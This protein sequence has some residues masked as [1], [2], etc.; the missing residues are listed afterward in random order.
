MTRSAFARIGRLEQELGELVTHL[1]GGETHPDYSRFV[2]D[3]K[4]WVEHVWPGRYWWPRM[5]EAIESVMYHRLVRVQSANGLGKTEGFAL[6]VLYCVFVLGQLVIITSAV[7]RQVKHGF[8][9]EIARHVMTAR[10]KLWGDLFRM[11]LELG[12]GSKA[13]ILAFSAADESRFQGLHS[14]NVTVILD[15]AQGL[16]EE[17][18]TAAMACAVSEDSRVIALGNPLNPTG[19]FYETSRSPH[20]KSH[21]LSALDFINVTE[22]R[23][24]VPGAATRGFINSIRDTYGESSPQYIARVTGRYPEESEEALIRLSWIEHAVEQWKAGGLEHLAEREPFVLACDIA[25]YGRDE[26]ILAVRHGPIL[27]ELVAWRG[28]STQESAERI[29]REVARLEADGCTVGLVLVDEVGV[30]GGVL[31]SL[32]ERAQLNVLGFNSS[33]AATDRARFLN[34]RAEAHWTLRR[35]LE[36]G[37]IALPEDD[38]LQEELGK[39]RW[40]VSPAGLIQIEAKD[41]LKSRLAGRSPDRL[42]AAAMA[43]SVKVVE[44][45][46]EVLDG[47]WW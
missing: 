24:V 27:R 26:C 36:D 31:D 19:P 11:G 8:M 18:F 42:D 4:G 13:G 34:A 44:P 20:W 29:A 47:F 12:R 5:L 10:G 28:K 7:E 17:I 22:G 33:T 1:G 46:E 38:L 37:G 21:A 32:A 35:L 9:R 15:E 16:P 14:D 6:Y 3:F 25:R 41:D 39:V 2:G 23:E 30:G 45:F 43:F 40:F